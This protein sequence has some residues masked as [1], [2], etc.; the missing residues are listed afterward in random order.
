M[1]YLIIL[2][3]LTVG[4]ARRAINV[5]N[6]TNVPAPIEIVQPDPQDIDALLDESFLKGCKAAGPK[7]KKHKDNVEAVCEHL[8]L[9][10]K[11][12]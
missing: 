5:T 2:L 1:K 7:G 8:L 4:C 6:V 10:S 9:K 12:D 11:E 3:L